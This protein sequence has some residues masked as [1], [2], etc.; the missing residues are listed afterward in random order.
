[1]ENFD[2]EFKTLGE[3]LAVNLGKFVSKNNHSAGTKARKSAQELKK[4]LQKLRE[5]ILATQKER[6]EAKKA[7]K[8]GEEPAPEPEQ[9]EEKPKKRA[10]KSKRTSKSKSA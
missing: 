6:Q 7:S 3:Q 5:D 8:E 9:E 1:M 10:S 4:L 2:E